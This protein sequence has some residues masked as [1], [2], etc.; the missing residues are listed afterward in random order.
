MYIFEYNLLL[1]HNSYGEGVSTLFL[2]VSCLEY[3]LLQVT[4]SIMKLV[5]ISQISR[6]HSTEW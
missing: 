5:A 4:L 2:Q 3:N 1:L 6:K